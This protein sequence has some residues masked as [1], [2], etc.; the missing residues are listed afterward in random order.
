[1]FPL[2]PTA[3]PR[4][5][6]RRGLGG[7]P[8]A[9]ESFFAGPRF[10]MNGAA[11]EIQPI[12]GVA[13][14]EGKPHLVSLKINRP[15]AVQRNTLDRGAVR[16]GIA[17]ARA[18]K[19]GDAAGLGIHSPYPMIANVTNVQVSGWPKLNAVRPVHRGFRGWTAIAAKAALTGTS[20]GADATR[21]GVHLAH[22]MVLH[23][24]K[25]QIA[26]GIDPDFIG[27]I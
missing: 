5:G 15:W 1:M 26:R 9:G 7:A 25:Y 22:E 18:G 12:D 2:G 21:F 13:F 16:R 11:P 8:I 23:F 17:F 3:I 6:Q 14:A 27:F 4:A 20:K 19:G 10:V 24:Y